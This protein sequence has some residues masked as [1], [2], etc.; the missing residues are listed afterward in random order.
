M[1]MLMVLLNLKCF[2]DQTLQL[3]TK[4]GAKDIVQDCFFTQKALCVMMALIILQP[5]QFV[6]ILVINL[7]AQNGAQ[8]ING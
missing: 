4:L 6:P 2:Q 1:L 3:S 5:T 7:V 8:N